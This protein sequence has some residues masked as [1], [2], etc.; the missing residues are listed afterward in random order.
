MKTEFLQAYG[1][2]DDEKS[3][4]LSYIDWAARDPSSNTAYSQ[5]FKMILEKAGKFVI[6]SRISEKMS[7][8]A[9]GRLTNCG[10]QDWE[11]WAYLTMLLRQGVEID[12]VWSHQ[13]WASIH[14]TPF[15]D[16]E[17]LERDKDYI[18]VKAVFCETVYGMDDRLT[19]WWISKLECPEEFETIDEYAEYY[20]KEND[21]MVYKIIS[22]DLKG[23]F[24]SVQEYSDSESS[25]LD[26][27][28][29]K[30]MKMVE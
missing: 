10:P 5:L 2:K 11:P 4:L 22:F 30:R 17:K 7:A 13:T 15:N 1:T 25:Q 26:P 21:S 3:L 14:L 24:G 8:I 16:N 23:L 27:L 18:L 6:D 19:Q 28:P 12:G 20:A 9:L 29:S